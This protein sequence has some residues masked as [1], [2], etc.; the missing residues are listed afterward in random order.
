LTFWDK[1]AEQKHPSLYWVSEKSQ[2]KGNL[3]SEEKK[4]RTPG[5]KKEVMGD[6]K[7]QRSRKVTQSK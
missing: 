1:T 4:R 2:G 5:I 7:A 3:Y 6:W